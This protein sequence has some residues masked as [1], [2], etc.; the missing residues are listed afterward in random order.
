VLPGQSG[1]RIGQLQIDVTKRLQEDQEGIPNDQRLL[2][3][4]G[5]A[6]EARRIV[7]SLFDEKR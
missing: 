1:P 2:V 5:G 3:V 6:V 7:K 4:L